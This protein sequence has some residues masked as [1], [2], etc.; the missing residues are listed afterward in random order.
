VQLATRNKHPNCPEEDW[1]FIDKNGKLTFN[2][3]YAKKNKLQIGKCWV[4]AV[5]FENDFKISLGK[6][7]RIEEG[8]YLNKS[9]EFLKISCESLEPQ[10]RYHGFHARI[11]EKKKIQKD[12][13]KYIERP[14]QKPINVMFFWL[15]SVSREKWLNG[16]PN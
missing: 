2:T 11:F 14:N 16:L 6:T 3:K 4:G 10:K 13:A 9:D 1:V 7:E 8:Q 5:R 12:P 15:D